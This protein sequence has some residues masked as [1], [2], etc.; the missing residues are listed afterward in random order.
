MDCPWYIVPADISMD[1]PW[2]IVLIDIHGTLY[3]GTLY[4]Q[5]SMDCLWYIVPTDIHGLSMVHCI[6]THHISTNIP[7]TPWR[8]MAGKLL[9]NT[10]Y[11]CMHGYPWTVHVPQW[12]GGGGEMA[13]KV[14]RESMDISMDCLCAPHVGR[15]LE[16]Y[17][18]IHCISMDPSFHAPPWGNYSFHV[19]Q[20]SLISKPSEKNSN[21]YKLAQKHFLSW[22]WQH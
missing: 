14:T 7:R 10:L 5:I 3:H 8:E 2:Y 16:S 1:C 22:A 4:P 18:G 13:A 15:W 12:E 19:Y 6:H 17:P 21:T 11:P 20:Y 9:G